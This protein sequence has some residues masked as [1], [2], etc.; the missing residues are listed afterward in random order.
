MLIKIGNLLCYAYISGVKTKSILLYFFTAVLVSCT[1]ALPEFQTAESLPAGTHSM[2]SG[3]FS[4]MGLNASSGI[5]TSH[6]YGL[7]D[8]LDWTTHLGLARLNVDNPNIKYSF[9]SGPKLSFLNDKW[10]VSA[11]VGAVYLDYLGELDEGITWTIT[12]T[13]YRSFTTPHGAHT[14]WLRTE[15]SYNLYYGNWFWA[16]A[17]YGY[18]F[19][20][21]NR[22]AYLSLSGTTGSQNA[23]GIYGGFG[24]SLTRTRKE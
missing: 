5:L 2:A 4:G 22:Y 19:K 12:P 8:H 21:G 20:Y 3:P 10:A 15:A 24:L 14:L 6:V 1:V 7:T 13:L 11:P 9:L 18:R 23:T 16:V 17:G